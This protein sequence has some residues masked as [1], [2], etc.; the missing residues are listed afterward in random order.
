M[1]RISMLLAV[2]AVS[3]TA[4]TPSPD[5]YEIDAEHTFITFKVNRFSM[6]DV[7]GVFPD[8]S[9]HITLDL[10][11]MTH[12]SADITIQT[13]SVFTGHSDG[14]D[15]AVKSAFFLDVENHPTITFKTKRVEVDGKQ[16]T[17]VGDLT[18]R[19][20]THE[21]RFPFTVKP[22]FKDP[23]GLTTI[24]VTGKLT[25]DRL[26]YKIFPVNKTL[27]N[28]APFIGR[29]VEIEINALAVRTE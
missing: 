8:A 4:W 17:A 14:R 24:A 29:E 12:T 16:Y 18:I 27:A 6:V 20:I 11:D 19:G 2:F 5:H 10:V 7:V 23:T 25:V 28:G 22:P 26:D 15:E 9:G 21:V 3:L 1:T 13:P